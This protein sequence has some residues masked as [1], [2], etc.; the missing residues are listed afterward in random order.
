MNNKK[1]ILLVFTLLVINN[2]LS[3]KQ[4]TTWDELDSRKIPEWFENSKFGIFVHW[5]VY[6]VPSWR[7]LESAKYASYAEWYYARVM[8]NKT[9]GGYEFHRKNYGQD[10]DYHDFAPMFKAE[11]Y[12][13]EFWAKTFKNSGAKYVVLTA[14]HHDGFCLW[15][16]DNEH[17]KNWNSND[18]GPNRDLLGELTKAVRKEGLKMGVYYSI[19]DWESIP[20]KNDNTYFIDSNYVKKYGIS[21]ERYVDE[22][23]LPQLYELVNKYNPSLIFSDAGEWLY[24]EHF[25]KTKSFLNWLYNE[26]SCKDEVVV[27]DRFCKGMPGN[28]GDYFSSEYQDADDKIS[29]HPWEE[30]RGIGGSYGFNRAEN[31]EDYQTSR[32][33]IHELISIVSRGGNLLLNV[34]PTADGRIPVIMQE[35]LLDI[36]QWLKVNGDAIYNTKETRLINKENLDPSLYFTLNQERLYCIFTNWSNEVKFQLNSIKEIES[37]KLLGYDEELEWKFDTNNKIIVSIPTLTINKIPCLHAWSLEI[38]FKEG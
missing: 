14:K 23:C 38:K 10:F 24:D 35:R 17:K 33:L 5:G 3:Q 12:N 19:P 11:L 6:S 28:H 9:N 26:S 7:K 1:T 21:P 4:E 30:S 20:R 34:G 18:I 8:D 27:N 37:I 25:W 16:T 22:I 32:E 29:N 31:L 2:L 13:P 15:D 36:G